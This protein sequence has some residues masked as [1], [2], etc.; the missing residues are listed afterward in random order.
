MKKKNKMKKVN[1]QRTFPVARL[2]DSVTKVMMQCAEGELESAIKRGLMRRI[3]LI[4][5]DS[6]ITDFARIAPKDGG[7][8][9]SLSVAGAQ[10]LWI[11]CDVALRMHDL[12]VLRDVGK[13]LSL[14]TK[15]DIL[16]LNV[17]MMQNGKELLNQ[18]QVCQYERLLTC[19]QDLIGDGTKS[20]DQ[21]IAALDEKMGLA[22]VLNEG[23]IHMNKYE[24]LD[25]E[26]E[27]AKLANSA[28]V[29]GLAFVLMHEY[30][31]YE[32]QH[33]K[34]DSDRKRKE[35]EADKRAFE[36]LIRNAYGQE[37]FTTVVGVLMA[38]MAS[39]FKS[40]TSCWTASNHPAMRDR[41]FAIYDIIGERNAKYGEMLVTMFRYWAKHNGI[42]GCPKA[43]S[44][45][46][47]R[48]WLMR[49]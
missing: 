40:A 42:A 25:M 48:R 8:E 2:F 43:N 21:L 16:R 47:I 49:I 35:A 18:I 4:D 19:A 14:Q 38:M 39:I 10:F 24:S 32:L 26:G 11:L 30:A 23:M 36:L 29:R 28:C 15:V 44:L 37:L 27:Y 22:D 7:H 6:N 33:V 20:E 34:D 9:V 17:S 1:I 31:H 12:S 46:A 5:M 3:E 45:S 13:E 41:I